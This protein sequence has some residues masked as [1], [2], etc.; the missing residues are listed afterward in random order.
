MLLIGPVETDAITNETL[1]MMNVLRVGCLVGTGQQDPKP[2]T[3]HLLVF[4]VA[5]DNA[6]IMGQLVMDSVLKDMIS[7]QLVTIGTIPNKSATMI[8][9]QVSITNTKRFAG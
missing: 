8:L 6:C 4:S 3:I 9:T 5:M 2:A 7:A 1:V